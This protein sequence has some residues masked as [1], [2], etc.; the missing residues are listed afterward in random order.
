MVSNALNRRTKQRMLLC[1]RTPQSRAAYSRGNAVSQMHD[2]RASWL[3]LTPLSLRAEERASR[4]G[5]DSRA[6][7]ARSGCLGGCLTHDPR[8]IAGSQLA[9]HPAPDSP[10]VSGVAEQRLRLRE[11][12]VTFGARAFLR[13]LHWG[14]DTDG[15]SGSIAAKP[16]RHRRVRTPHRRPAPTRRL[17]GSQHPSIPVVHTVI[18][19][20]GRMRRQRARPARRLVARTTPADA[21][22]AGSRREISCGRW[23]VL[24]VEGNSR[25]GLSTPDV[26][27]N[28]RV[29]P[30]ASAPATRGSGC[31][32][33]RRMKVSRVDRPAPRVEDL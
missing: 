13:T 10:T 5:V 29:R 18:L 23:P 26:G 7:R 12:Q 22:A 9:A 24:P 2:E 21:R 20:P 31:P 28:R 11:R 25:L 6:L 17:P 3:T 16:R 32:V 14:P 4:S 8:S 33:G 15:M 19:L 30:A 1:A 27:N